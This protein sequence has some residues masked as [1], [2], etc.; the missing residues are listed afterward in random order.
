MQSY[1]LINSLFKTIEYKLVT[2]NSL[3]ITEL[4]NSGSSRSSTFSLNTINKT[5]GY[6][7]P[8]YLSWGLFLVAI[9]SIVSVI[10][11]KSDSAF[12]D[13]NLIYIIFLFSSILGTFAYLCKPMK[14]TIYKDSFS[15]RTIFQLSEDKIKHNATKQFLTD[16][17]AAIDET[18]AIDIERKSL[19]TSAINQYETHNKNVED[20][21]NSGLIDEVL[22]NRICN[23]IHEKIFGKNQPQESINNVIYL[24]K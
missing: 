2:P 7:R 1:L 11:F 10:L 22:Y 21:F 5:E 13:S 8:S 3:K 18:K 12:I 14:S 19:T 4:F 9:S 20:L 24:N 23:S 6:S 17:N 16:L 15:N